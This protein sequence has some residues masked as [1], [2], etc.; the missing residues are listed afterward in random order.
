MAESIKVF[1]NSLRDYLINV[2]TDAYNQPGKVDYKYNNLKIYMDPKK[3]RVPHF[4]ISVNIS[5]ACYQIDP[6]EKISGSLGSDERFILL[7]ANRPNINGELKKHWI[8]LTNSKDGLSSSHVKDEKTV[9]ENIQLSESELRE[10]TNIITGS[11]IRKNFLKG[12]EK[13][14]WKRY[15]V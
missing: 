15:K 7:W 14:I 10:A 4:Y 11:G 13:Q 1:E 5:E 2:Q 8:Y 3:N 6:V 9:E 12:F